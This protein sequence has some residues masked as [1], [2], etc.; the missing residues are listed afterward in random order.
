MAFSKLVLSLGI[1]LFLPL[2]VSAQTTDKTIF[3]DQYYRAHV[4]AILEE[5]TIDSLDGVLPFQKVELVI[6]DGDEEGKKIIIDHGNLFSITTEQK[7]SVGDRVILTKPAE[8]PKED[9]YYITDKYRTRR[10]VYLIGFFFLLAIFFGRLKGLTGL[11]GLALS[12]V[13]IFY[14]MTPAI[15]K[16]Y[17]PL[18][19][20]VLGC[21]AI[22]FVSLYLSHGFNKRI[23]IAVLSTALTL[24]VAYILDLAFVNFAGLSG[25]GTE[26]AFY[27]QFA[28]QTINMRGL[29]LAGILL[30]VM[31]VLDD[32]TTAQSAAVDELHQANPALSFI[33]LYKRGLS[34][35]RE[36]I[37]SLINT[38]VLAYV[39]VSFPLILLFTLNKPQP[40][41]LTLNSNFIAEEVVRTLVGSSALI[42][43]VPVTT[44]FAAYF[45]SRKNS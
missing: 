22:T 4:T 44:F 13:I 19:V 40:L 25:T 34:V 1:F 33:E 42:I 41:W 7:V 29:L 35:G 12:V 9:F 8:S 43:A 6:D 32:I 18:L 5:S 15:L 31:G 45:F 26:E 30:G 17:D 37:A 28:A 36:H 16:G 21:L 14:G 39:G 27:L 20:A 10:L 2:A 23:S 38:L 11:L 24:G 3:G